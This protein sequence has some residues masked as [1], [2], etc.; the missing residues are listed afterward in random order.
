M[1]DNLAGSLEAEEEVNRAL[2]SHSRVPGQ[3]AFLATS[4][5][6]AADHM[7]LPMSLDRCVTYV[8]GSYRGKGRSSARVVLLIVVVAQP[9]GL[10]KNDFFYATRAKIGESFGEYANNLNSRSDPS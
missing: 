3:L 6:E 1:R 10:S 2:S 9:D 8:S 4:S 5:H 7:V